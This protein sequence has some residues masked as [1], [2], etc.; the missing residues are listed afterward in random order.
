MFDVA[1]HSI[2]AHRD[3]RGGGVSY[4]HTEFV[5][6][7]EIAK[8]IGYT[9][10]E[11]E[12]DYDETTFFKF[13]D[14]R[15]DEYNALDGAE[16]ATAITIQHSNSYRTY[17]DYDET[18]VQYKLSQYS[19]ASSGVNSTGSNAATGL[20][21]SLSSGG[22]VHTT[23]DELTGEQL[24]FDNVIVLFSTIEAYPGDSGDVQSVD[25]SY[26]GVGFYCTNGKCQYVYWVKGAANQPLCLIDPVLLNNIDYAINR[27]KTYL[28][29]VS[30]EEFEE[31]KYDGGTTVAMQ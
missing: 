9:D 3:S 13:T 15:T 23:V 2:V 28:S 24:G 30:L 8:A 16:D 27:G 11:M 25:Y 19:T 20:Y 17:F 7:D 14:Y 18:S 29:I 1:T 10:L 4:E 31:F 21:K 6:G 12:H 26:G 5:T 22:Y